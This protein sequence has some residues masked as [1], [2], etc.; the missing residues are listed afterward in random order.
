[1]KEFFIDVSNDLLTDMRLLVEGA[2]NIFETDTAPLIRLARDNDMMTA[3]RG[4]NTISSALYDLREYILEF[5]AAHTRE[6][7]R[8]L[9]ASK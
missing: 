7:K 1:M 9:K 8:Q 3:F 2:V 5:E 6:A 4:L